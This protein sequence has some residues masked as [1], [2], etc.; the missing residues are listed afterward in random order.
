MPR[1]EA[2]LPR[3]LSLRETLEA[4]DIFACVE[5]CGRSEDADWAAFPPARA[6]LREELVK[7]A[8]KSVS[9]VGAGSDNTTAAVVRWIGNA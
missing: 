5:D 1:G 7:L 9:T 6:P 4:N 2:F 3:V 8:E